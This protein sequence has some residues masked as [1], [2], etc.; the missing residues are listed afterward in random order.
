MYWV[1]SMRRCCMDNIRT[2]SKHTWLL[3]KSQ[4]SCVFKYDVNKEAPT[5]TK[6]IK[7]K[8]KRISKVRYPISWK[9]WIQP[10]FNRISVVF[11]R[12]F[13]DSILLWPDSSLVRAKWKPTNHV[14]HSNQSWLYW[15]NLSIL[16]FRNRLSVLWFYGL[17]YNCLIWGF[18][19]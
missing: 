3:F 10:K 9:S 5:K 11:F 12:F 8:K 15:I 1:V 2:Q 4:W 19:R 17:F 14:K 6:K 13:S 16:K 7:K 18:Y